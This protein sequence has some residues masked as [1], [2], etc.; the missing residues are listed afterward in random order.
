VRA[1]SQSL[2]EVAGKRVIALMALSRCASSRPA[3]PTQI[4]S[5]IVGDSAVRA[6]AVTRCIM[7]RVVVEV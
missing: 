3:G 6:T 4:V 2:V 1:T 5:A 7:L